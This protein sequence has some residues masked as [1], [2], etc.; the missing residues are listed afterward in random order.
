MYFVSPCCFN[1]KF[2]KLQDLVLSLFHA[3]C[4]IT[5]VMT[6][7][8]GMSLSEY[9]SK[10]YGYIRSKKE[11]KINVGLHEKCKCYGYLRSNK[12]LRSKCDVPVKFG[13]IVYLIP[14]FSIYNM[15][16]FTLISS[17]K[18][19]KPATAMAVINPVMKPPQFT[20]LM[21]SVYAVLPP[22]S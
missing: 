22:T 4:L 10:H 18:E 17:I 1:E 21:I 11:F 16:L 7:V 14:Y 8:K 15:I 13:D 19:G 6:F 12:S 20:R 3:L 2:Q 9:I 5:I